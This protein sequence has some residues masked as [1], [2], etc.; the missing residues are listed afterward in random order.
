MNDRLLYR[1]EG[2][3]R[4]EEINF[5]LVLIAV[6]AC[7]AVFTEL[8]FVL[9]MLQVFSVT[10]HSLVFST[11]RN[12]CYYL[13][14]FIYANLNR[15]FV[16]SVEKSHLRS[17]YTQFCILMWPKWKSL[18]SVGIKVP[19]TK[20]FCLCFELSSVFSL[21]KHHL[22]HQKLT[23]PRRKKRAN[24]CFQAD[25]SG[26]PEMYGASVPVSVSEVDELE[27]IILTVIRICCCIVNRAFLCC[28]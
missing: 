22:L 12:N 26:R 1:A 19:F 28:V 18:S 27:T 17:S 20:L 7:S 6:R 9:W 8:I 16:L 14:F 4:W 3:G 13:L 11:V 15:R 5:T 21:C 24:C 25:D 2:R 10:L 23:E